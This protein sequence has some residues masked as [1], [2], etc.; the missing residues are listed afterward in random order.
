MSNDRAR[1]IELAA[2]VFLW[3]AAVGVYFLS[4]VQQYLPQA[5]H[6]GAAYPGY[7][8]ACYGVA[9]FL[10]QPIAGWIA[11]RAGRRPTMVAG[12]AFSIPILALMM[13][14]PDERWFLGLSALLGVGAATMW[15]AFMA[16]VGETTPHE[17][18][19]RTMSLLNLAQM[20]GI[21][22]GTVAGVVAVDFVTYGAAFWACIAFNALA[23]MMVLRSID[24]PDHVSEPLPAAHVAPQHSAAPG[25]W[26]PGIV[27]LGVIVLFLTL[28]TSMHTP[29][30]GAYTRDVLEVKM[31]YMAMLFPAPALAAGVILWKFGHLADR[32][33]RQVPLIAGLFVAALCI[34]A[35]TLTD[36]PIIVVHLV[37]LAGLA[38]AISV[39][40]WGAAALD[41]TDV[42]S[43]GLWLGA[44]AAVQGLGTAGGQALG[45]LV[46][47]E[48][49]PLA[50][51]KFAAA[52]LFV[53]LVL[54]V[55][56]QRWQ[57]AS[58]RFAPALEPVRIDD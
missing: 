13:Q 56:H 50:P 1:A 9:R 25:A 10:W 5:L 36:S 2:V 11:D 35:L 30:I 21:G 39:P 45:G 27:V 42:G 43:R 20:A 54:I 15:P 48:W 52:L 7:A 55:A 6:A 31:S 46:G 28:G 17:R 51:F 18:R 44:L 57:A 38:Y 29:M 3:Q 37:V 8:M 22:I 14:I 34:F 24:A 19:A 16:H 58:P 12:M 26:K 53:A 4:L 49:G 33:G 40:A 47:S 41:A 23:L 32:Y